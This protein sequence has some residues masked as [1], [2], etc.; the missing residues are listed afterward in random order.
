[1][2]LCKQNTHDKIR[3]RS[4]THTVGTNYAVVNG[5]RTSLDSSNSQVASM[6]VNQRPLLPAD[7]VA[8]SMN[9]GFVWTP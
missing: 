2:E 8:K 7:F 9:I 1:V 4:L 6:V 3:S 5:T